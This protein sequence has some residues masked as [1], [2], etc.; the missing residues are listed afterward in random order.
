MVMQFAEQIHR[1]NLRPDLFYDILYDRII[2][3]DAKQQ[4]GWGCREHQYWK[5]YL[6][7]LHNWVT[8]KILKIKV[9]AES[10]YKPRMVADSLSPLQDY[11]TNRTITLNRILR[12]LKYQRGHGGVNGECSPVPASDFLNFYRCKMNTSGFWTVDW[13]A[14]AIW[15]CDFRLK[16]GWTGIFHYF[17]EFWRLSDSLKWNQVHKLCV[18]IH[19]FWFCVVLLYI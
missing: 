8:G 13:T 14:E 11:Q 5:W 10:K 2:P 9:W 7:L 19:R 17:V 6:Q 1:C 16:G 4:M 3:P 18:T 15:G 12:C